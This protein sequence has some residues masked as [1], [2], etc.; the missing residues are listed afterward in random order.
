MLHCVHSWSDFF[1]ITACVTDIIDIIICAHQHRFSNK[2]VY[3]TM[4]NR[5]Y[6]NIGTLAIKLGPKYV[7]EWDIVSFL[8]DIEKLTAMKT[9]QENPDMLQGISLLPQLN[10]EK[11]TKMEPFVCKLYGS[12]T[13]HKTDRV[14]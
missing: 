10:D 7:T 6:L 2:L 14:R 5:Q 9:L 11:L 1:L 4:G 8:F 12:K 13:L 3:V